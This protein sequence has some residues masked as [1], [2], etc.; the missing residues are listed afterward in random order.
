MG[1]ILNIKIQNSAEL[2]PMCLWY[3]DI[4]RCSY[5]SNGY[6]NFFEKLPLELLGRLSALRL[7]KHISKCTYTDVRMGILKL[8]IKY[9]SG[10]LIKIDNVD[11]IPVI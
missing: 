5:R 6:S 9:F 1:K 4:I 10:W 7:R 8:R 2:Q 3:I 11:S